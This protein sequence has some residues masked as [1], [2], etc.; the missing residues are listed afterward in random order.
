MMM[1]IL[2][3]FG[4]ELFEEDGFYR[5]VTLELLRILDVYVNDG[6]Y[7]PETFEEIALKIQNSPGC[8]VVRASSLQF[9]KENQEVTTV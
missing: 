5:D 2:F 6:H 7:S 1:L 4:F 8:D 3:V 9:T